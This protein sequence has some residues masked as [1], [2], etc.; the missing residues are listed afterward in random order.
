M[1]PRRYTFE[2]LSHFT[3]SELEYEK[4][5]EFNSAEGQQEL[6]NYCHRPKRTILE[7]LADFPHAV[8]KIPIEYLFEIFQPIRPRAFSI[9]SASEVCRSVR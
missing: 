5:V 7:V 4:L 6:Y 2:I 1:I 3:D 9:A 8:A